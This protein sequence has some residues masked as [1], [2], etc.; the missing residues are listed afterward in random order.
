MSNASMPSSAMSA[1]RGP[2]AAAPRTKIIDMARR[3]DARAPGFAAQ[4]DALLNSKRAEQ[5]D[6]V[7]VV[8]GIIADVRTRGDTA[9]V[10]LTNKFDNSNVTVETL[11]LSGAEIDAAAEHCD[12]K[13]LN[14]LN[15]AAA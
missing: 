5:E 15:V 2:H 3:L 1:A 11:R 10:E 12:A 6:V 9:L 13:A 7:A 4:F 14:A 8:R